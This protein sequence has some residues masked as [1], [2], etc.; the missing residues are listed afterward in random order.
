MVKVKK[1]Y[2]PTLKQLEYARYCVSTGLAVCIH[3]IPDR[4]TMYWIEKHRLEDY[5]KPV[6]LRKD[7]DKKDSVDNRQVFSEFDAWDKVFEMY[8]MVYDKNNKEN[9]TLL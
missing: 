3:P 5:K 6:F 4:P 8:K 9:I 1:I 2:S 7:T